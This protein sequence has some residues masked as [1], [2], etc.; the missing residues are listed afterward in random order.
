MQSRSPSD[1]RGRACR[2]LADT[3]VPCSNIPALGGAGPTGTADRGREAHRAPGRYP[4]DTSRKIPVRPPLIRGDEYCG[5]RFRSS[6]REARS[7]GTRPSNPVSLPYG[8]GYWPIGPERIPR[9]WRRSNPGPCGRALLLRATSPSR[10]TRCG[11]SEADSWRAA[12][13]EAGTARVTGTSP[14]RHLTGHCAQRTRGSA[15]A[16]SARPSRDPRRTPRR[17][18]AGSRMTPTFPLIESSGTGPCPGLHPGGLGA[19]NRSPSWAE[20]CRGRC[21]HS[22]VVGVTVGA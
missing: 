6:R 3:D 17:E 15:T 16:C 13:A 5:T 12:S 20:T 8:A 18:G 7:I 2:T 19:D 21:R 10:G 22:T 4:A 9:G 11:G 14:L 1:P